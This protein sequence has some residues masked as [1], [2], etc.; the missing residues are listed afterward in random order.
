M[1]GILGIFGS[2]LDEVTLR[3]LARDLSSRMKH[4]GPD[5][6][7]TKVSGANAIAHERLAIIDPESG[8]QVSGDDHRPDFA[9]FS[10]LS[11]FFR[12]PQ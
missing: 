12:T 7:G 3:R 2:D 5:W 8:E 6:C 9:S 11:S 4:R 1:C 10:F